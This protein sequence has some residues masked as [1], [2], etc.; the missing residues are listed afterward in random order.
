MRVGHVLTREL[1]DKYIANGWWPPDSA[2]EFLS[3]NALRYPS[4]E[5]FVD[6]RTRV[7]WAQMET[8]SDRLALKLLELGLRSGEDAIAHQLPNSVECYVVSYAALKAGL[9]CVPL[10]YMLRHAEVQHL[11]GNTDAVAAVL[12]PEFAGHD[13]LAMY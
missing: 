4:E 8:Y 6:S 11:L 3:R 12:R 9:I 10:G 1:R 13:Y 2:L 5:S 7:T